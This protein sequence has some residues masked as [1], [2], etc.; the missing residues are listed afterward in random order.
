MYKRILCAMLSFTTLLVAAQSNVRKQ[1]DSERKGGSFMEEK[2][3]E[4]GRSFV[5]KDSTYYVGYLLEGGYL[6][7]RA[8]DELGYRKASVPLKKALDKIEHDFDP[9]L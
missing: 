8:N 4:K 2:T 7:F 3:Y 9:L 5:R 1:I 6:F